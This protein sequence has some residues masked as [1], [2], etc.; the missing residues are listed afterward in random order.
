MKNSNRSF[1]LAMI[2]KESLT[3]LCCFA[4]LLVS[5]DPWQGNGALSESLSISTGNDFLPNLPYMDIA[6][7]ALDNMFDIYKEILPKLGGYIT[8][9]RSLFLHWDSICQPVAFLGLNL[10]VRSLTSSHS[11]N[12]RK[13]RSIGS[14]AK[15][16]L[17]KSPRPSSRCY[18]QCH[19]F[20]LKFWNRA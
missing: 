4:S 15:S 18:P 11:F 16:F 12:S 14:A 1:H 2:L 6:D 8:E 7:G 10:L 5:V 13:E 17:R 9:V 19:L 20:T 3:I